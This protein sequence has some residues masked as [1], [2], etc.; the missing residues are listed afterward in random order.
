MRLSRTGWHQ[1]SSGSTT[2]SFHYKGHASID[3]DYKH[4]VL[5]CHLNTDIT[6]SAVLPKSAYRYYRILALISAPSIISALPVWAL[7]DFQI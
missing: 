2:S 4:P 1:S 7:S 6:A 5:E 3:K